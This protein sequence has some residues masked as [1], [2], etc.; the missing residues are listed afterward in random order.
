[1]DRD[2]KTIRSPD[3]SSEKSRGEES[4]LTTENQTETS[5]TSS[6]IMGT[7]V[8]ITTSATASDSHSQPTEN[9]AVKQPKF[10]LGTPIQFVPGVGSTRAPLFEK[11]GLPRAGDLLFYFP[12]DYLPPVEIVPFSKLKTVMEPEFKPR[13]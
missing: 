12:R 4:M 10:Q 6:Q 8:V 9:N 7:E 1:M 13:A 3:S 2:D 11:L 5:K